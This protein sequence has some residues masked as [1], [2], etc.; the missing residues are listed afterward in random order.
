MHNSSLFD[1]FYKRFVEGSVVKNN[2]YVADMNFIMSS[3]IIFLF[4]G[5][6][7]NRYHKEEVVL[8]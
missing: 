6:R 3:Q 5:E 1:C 7:K 8:R 2:L 4:L